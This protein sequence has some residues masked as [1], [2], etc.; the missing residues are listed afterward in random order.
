MLLWLLVTGLWS[1]PPL[2]LLP[3]C[4]PH[5]PAHH[6][7]ITPTSASQQLS[8]PLLS[9]RLHAFVLFLLPWIPFPFPSPWKPPDHPSKPPGNYVLLLLSSHRDQGQA[10][11]YR[12]DKPHFDTLNPPGWISMQS[13]GLSRVFSNTRVQS[14][15]SSALSFLYSPALT[16]IHDHWKNHSLD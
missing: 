15:N 12:L 6:A 16:S 11:I 5:T 9:S 4:L 2:Q 3:C 10:V 8:C 13:K 14:I 7:C 1:N